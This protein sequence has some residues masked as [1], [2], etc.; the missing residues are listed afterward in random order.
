[1]TSNDSLA[2]GHHLITRR[3]FLQGLSAVGIVAIG[4]DSFVE[5][6]VPV[7]KHV[8]VPLKRLAEEFDGF[9]IAQLSDFHYDEHFTANVIRSAVRAVNELEVDLVALTGDF[10]TAPFAAGRLHRNKRRAADAAEPCA[11]LL[12]S[13]QS[14]NG[15]VA[16]LGNHDWNTDPEKI[17]EILTSRRILVLRNSSL[18]LERNG[19]RLWISGTDSF[20][21]YGQL[22]D[23]LATIPQ[24]ETVAL[25]VHQPDVADMVSKFPVDLQ[26]SGHSHG[27][28]VRIPYLGAPYLPPFGRKYPRGLRKVGPLTLYTNVGIGTMGLPIRLNCPPE[29]TV[30]TLRKA[31]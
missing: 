3:R 14:K 5:P 7:V 27:G 23:A 17:T 21:E 28:Q 6:N 22:N 20:P 4:I 16:V 12:Q 30:I 24:D 19:C 11:E 15:V 29:I 18:S 9:K 25:L 2:S 1:M 26:L 13:I 10:V 8:D 31:A